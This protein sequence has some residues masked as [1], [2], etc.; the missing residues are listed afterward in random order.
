MIYYDY[1]LGDYKDF[2][3][4]ELGVKMGDIN[5][6][7]FKVKKFHISDILTVTTGKML[8]EGDIELLN[9]MTGDSLFT[10]QLP[11]AVKECAPFLLEQHPQL[12][13]VTGEEVNGNNWKA[14]LEE[15]VAK[16]G[17]YFDVH[18]LPKGVHE[19][20]DSLSEAYEMVSKANEIGKTTKVSISELQEMNIQIDESVNLTAKALDHASVETTR[21]FYENTFED[22]LIDSIFNGEKIGKIILTQDKELLDGRRTLLSIYDFLNDKLRFQGKLFSEWG[23]EQQII[24]KEYEA[25]VVHVDSGHRN[26]AQLFKKFN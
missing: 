1:Q 20:K 8:S 9:Y 6:Q 17:E 10:H 18:P 2:I 4:K 24:F 22:W 21:K 19:E 16:Y 15:Q 25:T 14:W 26:T 13:E 23:V 11:R 3:Y 12:K 7:E 5:K